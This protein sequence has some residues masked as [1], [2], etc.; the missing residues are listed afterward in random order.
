MILVLKLRPSN[1]LRVMKFSRI[2]FELSDFG[3]SESCNE[4]DEYEQNRTEQK[5]VSALS[6]SVKKFWTIMLTE[7]W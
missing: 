5:F 3:P 2:Y 1:S 7:N 6:A 4:L